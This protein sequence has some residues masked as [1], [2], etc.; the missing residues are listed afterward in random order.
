MTTPKNRRAV[1]DLRIEQGTSFNTQTKTFN[2]MRYPAEV[3]STSEDFPHYTMFF[4]TKRQGD[5]SPADTVRQYRVD[6]SNTNRPD[7]NTQAGKIAFETALTFGGLQA[8][9]SFVKKVARTFGGR[10]GP[11]VTTGGAVAGGA[12]A[13]AVSQNDRIETL[14]ENR[15]RVYL[16]DVV[17]LYLSDNPSTSYKAYWKDAD[18]G[19]LASDDLLKAAS[20]LRTALTNLGGGEFAKAGASAMESVKAAL[21]GASPAA[22]SYFLKNANKGILGGLGD[23]QA[24]TES[25]LGVAVN[26]FTVQLFKNM[27][28]RTFT[29]SYVFLP[30]DEAEFNEVKNIIKTFKKYMHPTRNESTG[31]VFLGYPAEFEIQY[32]YRNNEN[33][34]LFKIGNCA[35]T[36]LKVEYG[37]QDFTTFRAVPG[38]PS[39]MKLQLS[40]TELEVLTADRIEEGY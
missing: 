25:S 32:F 34:H 29:F 26:P 23:I 2:V 3:G 24:L 4:I 31:G 19:A 11:I 13:A 28:F 8:G 40:F 30:K 15:E 5:V 21:K 18:I 14:T 35:L 16:K 27:G 20:S 7:R 12:A 17:A 9:S 22:A 38:A 6:V 39:E 36:D 33:N 37:G 10:A 1:Q